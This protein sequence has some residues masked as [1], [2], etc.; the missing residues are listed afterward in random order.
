MKSQIIAAEVPEPASGF[1]SGFGQVSDSFSASVSPVLLLCCDVPVQRVI[2]RASHLHLAPNWVSRDWESPRL[3]QFRLDLATLSARVLA[4]N[5][6]SLG[7]H[8]P[9]LQRFTLH[10]VIPSRMEG[11]GGGLMPQR[12]WGGPFGTQSLWRR[13]PSLWQE[14]RRAEPSCGCQDLPNPHPGSGS[15]SL[16][17]CVSQF[18]H[19]QTLSHLSGMP[20]G[21][22]SWWVPYWWNMMVL[23]LQVPAPALPSPARLP[24]CSRKD[25]RHCHPTHPRF[26]LCCFSF[27]LGGRR[28]D[29]SRL[30]ISILST[31]GINCRVCCVR[32]WAPGLFAG[33]WFQL[34][35]ARSETP[36]TPC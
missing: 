3:P 18:P 9:G 16:C 35:A 7:W 14:A 28:K 12:R 34:L 29:L 20:G 22:R 30:D 10:V 8:S 2:W 25:V 6:P 32:V 31:Q 17:D 4:H 26:L 27:G 11:W 24:L 23:C 19:L 1:A 15:D 33:C 5:L 21:L 13:N 36:Q